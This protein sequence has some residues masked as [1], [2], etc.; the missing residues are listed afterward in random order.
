MDTE[1]FDYLGSINVAAENIAALAS[2]LIVIGKINEKA[3]CNVANA[4]IEA[5]H[6]DMS[7]IGQ[8]VHGLYRLYER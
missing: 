4:Y 2:S 3:Y 5:I 1:A 7:V 8:C 6:T